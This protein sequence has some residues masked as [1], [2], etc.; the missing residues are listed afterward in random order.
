[1][2]GLCRRL[3]L[4]QRGLHAV[5]GNGNV[6]S[7]ALRRKVAELEKVRKKRNPRKDQFFVQV[8]ESLSFLDTATTPMILT[9][10]AIALF[11][12]VLMMV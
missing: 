9:V 5:S 1:M 4:F 11:A 7:E 3:L 10:V 8:P 6:P 12:K 2:Y